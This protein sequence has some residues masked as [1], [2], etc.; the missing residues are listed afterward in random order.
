[1]AGKTETKEKA[2]AK[3]TLTFPLPDGA[4]V[5][6]DFGKSRKTA[7]AIRDQMKGM[8]IEAKLA[9]VKEI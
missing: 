4:I 7:I 8:G 2:A 6:L 1:M 3:L 9:F 5:E